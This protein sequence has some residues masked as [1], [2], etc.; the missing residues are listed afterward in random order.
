MHNENL[1]SFVSTDSGS[2]SKIVWILTGS[3]AAIG[4]NSLA[5]GP[6]APNIAA[7]LQADITQVMAAAGGYGIGTAL[8]ALLLAGLIDRFGARRALVT[9]LSALTAAFVASALTPNVVGL[10]GA[11][12]M[13]GLAAGVGLPAIYAFAASVAPAGRENA[14]VGRVLI[15]WT[16]SLVAGVT[17]SALLSDLVGWRAVYISLAAVTLL[18]AAAVQVTRPPR[19][20]AEPKGPAMSPVKALGIRGVPVLLVIC[21]AYMTAFY[22][23]YAYI[24]DHIHTALGWPVSANAAIALSYGIGFGAAALGDPW[25]DRLGARRVMPHAYTAI[26]LVYAAM[27]LSAGSFA[28]LI[29]LAFLWGLFNHFGLNLIVAGLAVIDPGRRGAILGLNS[30]VTYAAASVGAVS[31]GPLYTSAGFDPLCYVAAGCVVFAALVAIIAG[32]GHRTRRPKIW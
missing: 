23:T 17:L 13:A 10:I 2:T 12:A 29:V 14:V 5:L 16:L 18:A 6:I 24:G 19:E 31:F 3:I 28:G 1:H 32:G 25:I 11:Q 21:F 9:A 7:A 22:G 4:A 26:A 8:G 30:A 27:A 20:H 15:G